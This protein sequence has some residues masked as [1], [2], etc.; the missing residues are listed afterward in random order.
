MDGYGKNFWFFR[1][2]WDLF[3]DFVLVLE[4]FLIYKSYHLIDL[5]KVLLLII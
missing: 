1:V 4:K 3:V 5:Y 2:F